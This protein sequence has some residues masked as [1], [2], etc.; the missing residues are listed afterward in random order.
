VFWVISVY[1]TIRNTLPKSG[2]F[3]LGHLY[4]EEGKHNKEKTWRQ[5]RG[6]IDQEVG[7]KSLFL[8]SCRKSQMKSGKMLHF[9]EI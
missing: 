2:T 8:D 4:V 9:S 6:R 3:L 7:W 5:K 1:F